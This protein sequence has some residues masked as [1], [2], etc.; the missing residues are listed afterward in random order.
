MAV[1]LV[2]VTSVYWLWHMDNVLTDQAEWCIAQ[3]ETYPLNVCGGIAERDIE[4]T[5]YLKL[6][7]LS[8]LVFGSTALLLMVSEKERS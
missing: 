3:D 5:Y 6:I 1:F 4:R 8:I 7:M 2:M